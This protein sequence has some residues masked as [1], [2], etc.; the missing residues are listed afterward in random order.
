MAGITLIDQ[1]RADFR[2]EELRA[3]IVRPARGN[4]PERYGQEDEKG[5]AVHPAKAQWTYYSIAGPLFGF[6]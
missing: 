2:L 3:G 6:Q 5:E 4:G 1:E